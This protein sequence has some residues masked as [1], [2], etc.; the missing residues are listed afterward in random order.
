VAKLLAIIGMMLIWAL[1]GLLTGWLINLAADAWPQDAAF[2]PPRCGNCQTMRT[3]PQWSGL[4]AYLTGQSRCTKCGT[5]ISLRWPLVE[6]LAAI[7][8]AYLYVLFGPSP[9]L[10]IVTAYT[11]IL[12]LVC[13]TDF[14]HRLI[15]N[16]VTYPAV[17]AA[18]LLSFVT[19]GLSTAS[20]FVGA[21]IGLALTGLIYL[22]GKLFV[23]WLA[24]RGRRIDEVAFG[25]G[26][27]KLMVFIGLITGAAGVL[28][29]LVIGILIGG[30]VAFGIILYGVIRRESKLYVPYAYG[31]YLAVAGWII[32]IQNAMAP[33]G[34]FIR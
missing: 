29:A 32:L 6:L 27:V 13:V 34:V 19:P 24:R 18:L 21:L 8:F 14:E 20:A 16:R 12:A 22:G 5:L 25:L 23:I 33:A 28:Q 9:L 1:A 30:V 2:W 26:D 3:G 10:L 4:L 31:P 17:V 7:V 11:A 15:L